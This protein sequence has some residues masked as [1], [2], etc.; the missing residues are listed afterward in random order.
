[1]HKTKLHYW[2]AFVFCL[3]AAATQAVHAGGIHLPF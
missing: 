2:I 1:M 3:V